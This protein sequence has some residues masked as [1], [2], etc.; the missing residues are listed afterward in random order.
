MKATLPDGTELEFPDG[1][2]REVIRKA[3]NEA[4]QKLAKPKQEKKPPPK[5]IPPKPKPV[6]FK[7]E[8]KVAVTPEIK[9]ELKKEKGADDGSKL[10]AGKLDEISKANLLMMTEL[11]KQ[12]AEI[13]LSMPAPPDG[14][15]IDWIRDED[16][17]TEKTVLT[18][19]Y[20]KKTLN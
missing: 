7:P 6:E 9:L 4:K 12:I 16:G 17:F 2:S 13:N 20:N 11:K 19:V 3:V 14:W 5:K 10:L 8:I 18:P 1:T 15:E